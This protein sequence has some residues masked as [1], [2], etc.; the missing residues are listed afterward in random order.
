MDPPKPLNLK[1][2]KNVHKSWKDFKEKWEIYEI[3]S[4][5]A[6]K[7]PL[8]RLATFLH[9]AGNDAL[10]KYRGFAFENENDKRDIEKVLEKFDND[11]KSTV[12][13]LTERSLFYSRKQR[14]DETVE[15]YVTELR[16]LFC[17]CEFSNSDEALR[18]Q[19]SLNIRNQKAKERLFL[20]AQSNHRSLTFDKA[21]SIV[22]VHESL[23]R[24]EENDYT[25]E[26]NDEMEI[27][28]VSNHGKNIKN[29]KFC[30]K[31]HRYGKCPAF[32]KTCSK[33]SK[34]NHFA[35]VC[36][37]KN[38]VQELEEEKEFLVLEGPD[39]DECI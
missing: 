20:E 34:K 22:K 19:F 26:K 36:K 12:N 6:E 37:T 3:A 28:K 23:Q 31:S 11:C 13:I 8:K 21:I 32:G 25:F 17:E 35:A 30:G 29:C 38:A 15:Q 9:V 5:T 39:E 27:D 4:G 1:N 18:D 14:A 16:K 10:E 33:C 24:S 7:E 2:S